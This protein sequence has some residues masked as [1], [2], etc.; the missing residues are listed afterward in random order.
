[1][2]RYPSSV[3]ITSNDIP[4]KLDKLKNVSALNTYEKSL[5]ESLS[6]FYKGKG[7][8]TDRQYA[9][10]NKVHEQYS[11]E[12]L[13]EMDVWRDNF[14]QEM[15]E[16]FDIACSYYDKTGYFSNIVSEWRRDKQYI[17]PKNQYEKICH[18]TY[19]KRVIE[20][21]KTPA[22]FNNGDLVS[23]RSTVNASSVKYL[24]TGGKLTPLSDIK[25][26][27]MLFIVDNMVFA[28]GDINRYCKV[29]LMSNPDCLFLIRE[30]DLKQYRAG[31]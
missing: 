13:N 20:N 2:N 26:T 4:E 16:E 19:A 9:V 24:K 29:F 3:K 22:K 8:I 17:P 14:T 23:A 10:L 1:M 21:R 18:N 27:S 15:R 6:D 30:K 12:K 31:K 5:V 7:Y 28:H 25:H 11:E